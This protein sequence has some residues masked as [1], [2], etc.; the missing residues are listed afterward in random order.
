MDSRLKTLKITFIDRDKDG[1]ARGVTHSRGNEASHWG[2]G[3]EPCDISHSQGSRAIHV[4]D[5]VNIAR[6]M[7]LWPH[8][9]QSFSKLGREFLDKVRKAKPKF[10]VWWGSKSMDDLV[11][12]FIDT[13]LT[14]WPPIIIDF[15]FEHLDNNAATFRNRYEGNFVIRD[16]VIAINGLVS[17]E[18]LRA[19]HSVSTN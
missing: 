3:G 14:H 16:N 4:M 9:K 7:L 1:E 17:T 19:R 5:S 13:I 18:G 2:E 15:S 8:A 12:D 11:K 10:D 6:H